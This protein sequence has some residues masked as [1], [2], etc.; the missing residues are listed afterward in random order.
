MRAWT[1]SLDAAGVREPGLR[2]DY[3]RQRQLVRRYRRTAYLAV[4]L[5]L[6]G[7]AL[8]HVVAMT[9]VMHHGDN[10]LDTGPLPRRE[11]AWADW[12]RQVRKALETGTSDIPLLRTLAH[13]V[14]ARPRLRETVAAYL[15]TATAELHFAG[16]ATEAEYQTYVDAYSFPAFMLIADLLGPEGDD[17]AYRAACRTFIDGSQRLDFVNDLAEDLREGRMG[18]PA[19]TLERFSLG[20][21]ELAAGR[22]GA[23]LEALVNDQV[24]AARASLRAALELPDLIPAPGR[25]LVRALVEIELLTADAVQARG[26]GVLHGSVSP[27]PTRALRVLMGR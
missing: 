1:K 2:T 17:A 18:I 25:R 24:T 16:F 11:A 6:R 15:S 12:E 7:P 8:A 10:L 22:G 26:A 13:T 20:A 27:P 9:A 19:A 3:D 4:R 14:S 5:L 23:D 21:A